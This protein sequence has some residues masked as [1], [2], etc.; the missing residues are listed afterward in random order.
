VKANAVAGTTMSWRKS[1][2]LEIQALLTRY[3]IAID[4]HDWGMLDTV[5]TPDARIDYEASA[6]ITRTYSFGPE[7]TSHEGPSWG[8]L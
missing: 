4:T 6:G 5:F 8:V 2:R 3:T 1:N 7:R